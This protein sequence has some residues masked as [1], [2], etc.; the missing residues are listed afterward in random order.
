MDARRR[1]RLTRLPQSIGQSI[2]QDARAELD[3]S[4][5]CRQ[6]D[7]T[8]DEWIVCEIRIAHAKCLQEMLKKRRG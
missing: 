5:I 1:S 3:A 4:E 2:L 7:C 6:S 8:D